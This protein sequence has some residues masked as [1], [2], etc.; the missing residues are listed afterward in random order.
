MVSFVG[1]GAALAASQYHRHSAALP[2]PLVTYRTHMRELVR[3]L[4]IV[5]RGGVF[6]RDPSLAALK[7]IFQSVILLVAL[8]WRLEWYTLVSEIAAV[9]ANCTCPPVIPTQ[10]PVCSTRRA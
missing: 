1:G 7:M 3:P 10:E 2:W 9:E 5:R 6:F 4:V 8:G